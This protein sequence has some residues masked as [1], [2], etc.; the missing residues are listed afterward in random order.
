LLSAGDYAQAQRFRYWFA[1]R[2]AEVM[3]KVDILV[4]PTVYESAARLDE[5]AGVQ[6]IAQPSYT[7]PF[8]LIGYPALAIP[9]GF[10]QSDFP[11]STQIVG[12]PFAEA[13]VLRVG[14]AYQQITDHHL[15]APEVL[16]SG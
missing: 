7:G 9:S 10:S 11:L 4:T 6:R 13:T 5:M 2:V 15:K 12:A 14:H 3:S 1:E 16:Y 8:S